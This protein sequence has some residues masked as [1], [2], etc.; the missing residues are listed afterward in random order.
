MAKTPAG[1][2]AVLERVF[3]LRAKNTTVKTEIMAGLT[4]FVTMGYI[5][6]VNP[7]ILAAAGI[8]KDAAI[9][10]TIWSTVF[11]SLL[12]GIWANFPI[13][14]APGMG[15]NAFFTYTVVLGMGLSWQ[16]ALGAVFISGVVFL[17]LTFCGVRQAI[18]RAVPLNLKYAIGIGIGMF[19]AFVGLQGAGVVVGDSATLV[20]AGSVASAHFE[21]GRPAP[22]L[23][24][25]G[26]VF[27]G[28][29]MALN[30]R[31]S[32]LLG[33]AFT[34]AAGMLCGA[35]PVPDGIAALASPNV[36]SLSETFLA[37]DIAGAWEYGVF[38]IIFTFTIVELFDNMGTLIGLARKAD[39]MKDDGSMENIDRALAADAIGTMASAA[40]GTSTVTSYVEN[41]AG[42]AAGGRTGLTAV[43]VAA[44]FVLALF[45]A[46]LA[47]FV[48]SF[49]TAPAL[50]VV[51]TL[52]MSEVVHVR[53][54]DITEALPAFLT[55][56]MMPLTYSI[57]NG[58]AF[59]F[60]SHTLL[61]IFSGKIRDV[62]WVTGLISLAFMANF[63]L[64]LG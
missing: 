26:L 13:A 37:M 6:F 34:V 48:P 15:L 45:F 63:A 29:L 11:S 54:D 24:L 16:T 32:L 47:G 52:M 17:V 56:V 58:L 49:A 60:A 14:A 57:A 55:I 64:R 46:P 42:I 51:G 2:G 41:G 4:T 61:K 59:G 39:L 62:N 28:A 18:I 20:T 38:S 31:C 40:L 43:T 7:N 25:A 8:P 50:I 23:T 35:A 5:L 1:F 21:L 12:M 36:P 10:A 27:T 30:V 33:I 9:A 3:R 22:L 44:V 53:F 19:I